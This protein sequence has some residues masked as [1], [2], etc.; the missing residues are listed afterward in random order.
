[1]C[2]LFTCMFC[3]HVCSIHMYA[4][5]LSFMCLPILKMGVPPKTFEDKETI[6][7]YFL[8]L[9]VLGGPCTTEA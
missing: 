4:V 5:L 3:S 9:N 6:A 1:M 8:E 2:A 7:H